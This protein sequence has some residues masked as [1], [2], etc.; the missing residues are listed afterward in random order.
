M[1]KS[2]LEKK[3][4]LFDLTAHSSSFREISRNSRQE[5][6]GGHDRPWESAAS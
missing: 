2:N 6:M 1:T 4:D 3:K 5:L